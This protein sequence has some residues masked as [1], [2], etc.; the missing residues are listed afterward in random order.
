M[1]CICDELGEIP[2]AECPCGNGCW[3]QP[4]RPIVAVDTGGLL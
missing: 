2:G 4:D 3:D 1:V